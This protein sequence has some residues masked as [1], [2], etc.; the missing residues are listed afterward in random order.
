M[1]SSRPNIVVLDEGQLLNG[2]LHWDAVAA[3]GNLTTYPHT[4]VSEI[5]S[6]AGET[7]I[8]LT[9]KTPLNASTL[10]ALPN[11]RFISVLATG[12]NVVDTTAA[13]HHGIPVSNVPSYGTDSV[14]QHTFAL[15]LE[16]TNHVAQHAHAVS[17]GHW[18]QSGAW[19]APLTSIIELRGCCLGLIGRGRI[20]RRVAEIACAFG[21]EVIMAS[22][23]HPNGTEEFVSL[24]EIAKTADIISL[25]CQLTETNS[26]LINADFLARMKPS[27]FLINTA[28]GALINEPDLAVALT[29]GVIAGAA[30]DVLSTE[31]PAVHHPLFLAPNCLIT[32]HIAWTGRA[33]RQRLLATTAENIAA[34]LAS[35][36]IH[37]VNG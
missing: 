33:A 26:G 11:L 35:A 3:L 12:F 1:T 15:I 17:G 4:P 9:N 25:H 2:G 18:A 34:F 32:P 30:L 21:M 29:H 27:A 14:A 31:P 13:R 10:H 16:L 6:R 8:L 23:S 7:Q 20:A 5:L 37:V 19:S 22:T 28:R 36:P 24:H